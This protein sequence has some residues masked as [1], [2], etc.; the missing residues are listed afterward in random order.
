V[1]ATSQSSHPQRLPKVT[2]KTYTLLDGH[3]L[4][5]QSATPGRVGGH[6]RAKA[7][8]RLDCRTALRAIAKGGYVANRVFFADEQAAEAAGYRPCAV[9]LAAEYRAWKASQVS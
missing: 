4:A 3:G 5:Y 6:R 1:D 7:Y 8:G 2:A 9:C